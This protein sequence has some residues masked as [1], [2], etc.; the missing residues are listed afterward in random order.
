MF[1][2]MIEMGLKIILL[3]TLLVLTLFYINN[4]LLKHIDK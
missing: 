2:K 4:I 3:V 1:K